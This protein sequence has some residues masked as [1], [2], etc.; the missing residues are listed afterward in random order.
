[1]NTSHMQ[2]WPAN[3]PATPA[4][5]N[6]VHPV[7]GG[8]ASPNGLAPTMAEFFHALF[9]EDFSSRGLLELRRIGFDGSLID[10]EFFS[11]AEEAHAH[12]LTVQSANVY[13][14]V[15]L[16]RDRHGDKAHVLPLATCAWL[17]LDYGTEGHKKSNSVATREE[18]LRQINSF[19]IPPSI[20]VDSG[21]G[22]HLYWLFYAPAELTSLAKIERITFGLAKAFHGDCTWDATRI[23]RV[24]GTMNMKEGCPT[25]PCT[26][27]DWHPD[28][29]YKLEDFE[30]WA[31]DPSTSKADDVV[32][33]QPQVPP[34]DLQSLN[35]PAQTLELIN[36]GKQEGDRYLSRSEADMAVVGA[37]VGD[38]FSDDQIR[39]I[40][41]DHRNGIG[42]RYRELGVKGDGYLALTISKVR[43]SISSNGNHET[44][45]PPA[46]PMSF[47]KPLS[48]I[49]GEADTP[50][51]YLV[52]RL[53]EKGTIGFSGGEPK[54]AK[55]LL[56][57][58]IAMAL[59]TGTPVLGRF[60]VEKRYKILFI[61]EEDPAKLIAHRVAK[62]AKGQGI[63]VPDDAYFRVAVRTGFKIDNPEWFQILKKEL[64]EF[65]P[66]L[67]IVDVFNKIH[68]GDE[69]DQKDM[70]R[71]MGFF[72]QLRRE[73]GCTFLIPHHFGKQGDRRANLRL[74]G[75]SVLGGC[76][77]CSLYMTKVAEN[78]Y[79][80]EHES[81]NPTQDP[82]VFRIEDLEKDEKGNVVSARLVY[83]GDAA[84]AHQ[85]AK[86]D[87]TLGMVLAAFAAG[88]AEACTVKAI[89]KTAECT[90]NTARARLNLLKDSGKVIL[91]E[92]AVRGRKV[93]TYVPQEG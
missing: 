55:S 36:T 16:R 82:F 26:I 93:S 83:Q 12:A 22:F 78:T 7:A 60:P 40:F 8:D 46:C 28:R 73:Y 70:T 24:P 42:D 10:A 92:V 80:V 90:K 18:S 85:E 21:H 69:N 6:T 72:E 48:A 2:Q 91:R 87:E 17:D 30:P 75:S 59:A 65:R 51:E 13:F 84:I 56:A 89:A 35:L 15:M 64:D 11:T 77:D 67:V 9:P 25:V 63:E 32:F 43:A 1:M 58:H 14:G 86:L 81:K 50:I 66:D 79:K 41:A 44:E 49:M 71:V 5:P 3:P 53:L 47:A 61:E 20:V 39:S 88:G 27:I 33:S 29:R 4:S 34:P 62:M 38:G 68:L 37:L 57:I 54:S 23:L 52:E 45:D 31:K 74:R 19:S 76:S